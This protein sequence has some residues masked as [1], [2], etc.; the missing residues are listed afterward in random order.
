MGVRV[1]VGVFIW[2][3]ERALADGISVKGS[4]RDR[5]K[6]RTLLTFIPLPPPS[7]K[8]PTAPRLV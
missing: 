1:A 2:E 4:T 6:K 8:N 3:R 5:S 7:L